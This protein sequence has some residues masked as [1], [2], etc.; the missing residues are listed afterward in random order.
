MGISLGKRGGTY[1]K[2]EAKG[3][4]EA[5]KPKIQDFVT[6]CYEHYEERSNRWP[7]NNN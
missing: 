1:K 4:L 2:F 7:T 5:L 3:T 6:Q